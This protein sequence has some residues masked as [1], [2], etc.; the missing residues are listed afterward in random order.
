MLVDS[1]RGGSFNKVVFCGYSHF[2][3]SELPWT[4][5]QGLSGFLKLL[6]FAPLQAAIHPRPE[7]ARLFRPHS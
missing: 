6:P 3:L 1:M 5:A 7:K 2:V 4:E